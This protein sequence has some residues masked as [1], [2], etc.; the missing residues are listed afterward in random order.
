MAKQFDRLFEEITSFEN[1]WSA[2]KSAAKGKR[3]Q[4]EVADFEVNADWRILEI[5]AALKSGRWQ[6]GPYRSFEINDP[7]R[8]VV[9]AAP[10]ADRVV[11]H[12]LVRV[13]EP[14]FERTFIG[15]SYANRMGKGT[16]AAL[17]KA[18][19]WVRDYPYVL[20]CDLKQF[21]PSVDHVV[22]ANVLTRKL[23]CMPTLD[24]CKR[25]LAS[26]VGLLDAEYAMVHFDDDDL[27]AVARP[28]GLPIGNLT[29]QFW[30]NVLLNE[31][32][33]FVKRELGCHAYL[34]YVDDFLLFSKSKAELWQWKAAIVK[35]LSLLRL[36]LHERRACVATT[37]GGVPFLGLRLFANHRRLKSRNAWA[38]SHRL[39][40]AKL[41][42]AAGDIDRDKFDAKLK[43][44]VA[45][46]AHAD[47]WRL[48]EKIFNPVGSASSLSK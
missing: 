22:M 47:T 34:R 42:L 17:N 25:I 7:K 2:F 14:L 28:R 6:P 33:Q 10:F 30:A 45:H 12:A 13:I 27:F 46:A 26:G 43:G 38:F 37:A 15:D 5:Q 24:L 36:T 41:A 40:L 39:R 18:Q 19:V 35:K 16:H 31:L 20:Q 23:A 44:W 1:L 48:R 8:R 29:S 21:F 4:V 9:S 11:H 3:S 32:D